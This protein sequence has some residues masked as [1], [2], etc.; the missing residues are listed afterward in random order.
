MDEIKNDNLTKAKEE[1]EREIL[2]AADREGIL[3][4]EN[5]ARKLRKKVKI[6]EDIQE[7]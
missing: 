5:H 1:V 4:P 3:D 2:L 6:T 7:I